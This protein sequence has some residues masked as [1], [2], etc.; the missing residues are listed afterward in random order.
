MDLFDALTVVDD[1]PCRRAEEDLWFSDLPADLERAKALCGDC[2]VR[3]ACLSGALER[4]EY[5]GVWGGEILDRGAVIARKRPRGR[6][7]K[8]DLARDAEIAAARAAAGVA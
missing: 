1:L 4:R 2:P 6:P 8:A 3:R 5:C 7:S